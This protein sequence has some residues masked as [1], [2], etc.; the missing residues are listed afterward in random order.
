LV[1][2]PGLTALDLDPLLSGVT[3]LLNGALGNLVNAILGDI[4]EVDV[5]QT[6]AILHLEL[7]P[8]D[9][10]LL[11]LEV[12]LDDCAGGPVVVDI[13]AETGKGN[14]LGNLLC[15]LLGGGGID[16]GATLGSILDQL[17]G[18]LTQ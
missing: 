5:K 14:L 13:T 17:L 6:C 2:L 10:N 15:G 3:G 8:L 7:G 16:L 12:I 1:T 11:G 4:L 18:A 9:L